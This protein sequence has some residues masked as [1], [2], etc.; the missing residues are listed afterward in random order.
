MNIKQRRSSVFLK[1]FVKN[2]VSQVLHGSDLG[3][4]CCDGGESCKSPSVFLLCFCI[5]TIG[6]LPQ[7]GGTIASPIKYGNNSCFLVCFKGY[8][9][10]TPQRVRKGAPE[11]YGVVHIHLELLGDL[12][13]SGVIWIYLEPSG[14]M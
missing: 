7:D 5:V 10:L 11:P 2:F 6:P 1:D 3:L 9:S 8:T 14:A 4:G 12:E 13:L